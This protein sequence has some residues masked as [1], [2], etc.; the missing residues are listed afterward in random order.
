[1][2][3]RKHNLCVAT[4][5][6]G[7]LLSHKTSICGN[8]SNPQVK[9]CRANPHKVNRPLRLATI[10]IRIR[11]DID[12]ALGHL[13]NYA[14]GMRDRCQHSLRSTIGAMVDKDRCAFK[15]ARV[16]WQTPK[17]RPIMISCPASVARRIWHPASSVGAFWHRL[18]QHERA[19]RTRDGVFERKQ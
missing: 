9:R 13:R 17:L 2:G 18:W 16:C 7:Q 12:R 8:R 3:H 1:M 10:R 4:N 15:L 11:A 5:S 6:G 14:P 19:Q